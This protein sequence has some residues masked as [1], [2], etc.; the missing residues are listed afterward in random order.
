M[1]NTY[2]IEN[3]LEGSYYRSRS[4]ARKGKEG[5]IQYAEKSDTWFGSDYQAYVVKVRPTFERTNPATWGS[6]F[7][8]TIAVKIGDL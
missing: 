6:D 4:F 3:L 8:A 7:Y 5:I 2:S 1:A